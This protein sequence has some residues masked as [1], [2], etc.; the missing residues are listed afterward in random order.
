MESSRWVARISGA[1]CAIVVAAMVTARPALA[2]PLVVSIPS[3]R[4]TTLLSEKG[5]L[6]NGAGSSMFTGVTA[7]MARRRALVAFDVAAAIPAG[8][9]IVSATL[10]LYVSRTRLGETSVAVHRVTAAWGEGTSD[11]SGTEGSGAPATAGDATWTHRV[12]PNTPWATAGGDFVA[13]A[14]A[15]AVVAD[16]GDFAEWSGPGVTADVQR[17]LDDGAGNQGWILVSEAAGASPTKRY[18]TRDGA[19][20]QRPQLVVT[21][22]PPAAATVGACCPPNGSCGYVLAPGAGCADFRGAGSLCAADTCPPLKAAC[23]HPDVK[24]TCDVRTSADCDAVGGMWMEAHDACHPDICPVVLEPFVDPL[25]LPP[26]ATAV[27]TSASGG[28]EYRLTMKE[29]KQKLHRDLPPT[30]VWGYDDGTHGPLYPGPTFEARVG[31]PVTVTWANDLRDAQ[32][33]LRKSHFLPVDPCPHGAHGDAPRTVVHLHGGHVPSGFDGQPELTLLPGEETTYRYPN[34]QNAATLWYHDHALGITRLNVTMGLSGFYLLRDDAEDALGLPSGAHEVPLQLQDRSFRP[35][36]SFKY[37]A[38][39]EEHFFGDT[40]LVNGKVWPYLQVARGRYRFRM[41][42]GSGSRTYALSLR[43][44]APMVQIGSDGGLLP[45][46]VDKTNIIISPGERAD[47]LID[48]GAADAGAEFLLVNQAVSPYPFGDNEHLVTR[49]MKFVVKP[50]AGHVAP[51][52]AV[53]RPA[54]DLDPSTATTTR[55]FVLERSDEGCGGGS[56]RING[57]GWHDVTERP[58]LGT[59]EIWR[60]VNKSG[61][62]HPMHLHLAM[63]KILDRQAFTMVGDQVTPMMAPVPADPG[64]RGW[65]DTVRVDPFEIVRVVTRFEDY[66]GRFPYHCHILEHEDHEMMRQFETLP[67]CTDAG[68]PDGGEGEPDAGPPASSSGCSCE[69]GGGGAPWVGFLAFV[70]LAALGLACSSGGSAP[71]SDAAAE[72]S[73]PAPF[74]ATCSTDDQC[75]SAVCAT[76][77]DGTSH[78]SV[79]CT[80]SATCP[81]GTQGRKCN[82]KGVCAF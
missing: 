32:G 48:F 35:D 29:T 51:T 73:A 33:A 47:V 30:T 44:S 61:V 53:L 5:S 79:A 21:F 2:D 65:K 10:R 71:R 50:E 8:S 57:L 15:T 78:C 74:G 18:G 36:G 7:K 66:A 11:P 20:S 22:D 42:N 58:R 1:A 25:P 9:T 23:C 72:A 56:W 45:A 64:Q 46:G 38:T 69:A 62:S 43:P 24:A 68:C 54:D 17:W 27:A 41:L 34:Q 12:W 40:V 3:A 81:E 63:F 77:G 55:D 52:P 6:S 13:E 75:E 80:D 28:V 60:F 82:G 49:V 67:A 59:T 39:W 4:D 16:T 31:T 76:F 26:A 19:L 37:P 70:F 14:T